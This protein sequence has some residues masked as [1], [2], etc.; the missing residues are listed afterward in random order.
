ME[1][2]LRFSQKKTLIFSVLFSLINGIVF[3]KKKTLKGFFIYIGSSLDAFN[4]N[5][6]P[7]CKPWTPLPAFALLEHSL[8]EVSCR[9]RSEAQGC[10]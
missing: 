8:A 7:L 2:L 3:T 9:I 4:R 5:V 1:L 10:P 6:G